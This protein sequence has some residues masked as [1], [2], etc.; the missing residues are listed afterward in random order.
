MKGKDLVT[1]GKETKGGKKKSKEKKEKEKEAR[2]YNHNSAPAAIH[3]S[4]CR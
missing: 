4:K 3:P 1:F 2:F